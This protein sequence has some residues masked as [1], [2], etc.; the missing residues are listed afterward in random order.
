[1]K[2]NFAV[3]IL[4]HKR[5]SNVITYKTLKSHW[6]TWPIYII[7]DN[8]DPQI[9]EY[10]KN[11]D[12]V[13][14]F[15]KEKQYDQC[16]TIDNM[17][18]MWS[19]LYARNY[20]FELAKELWIDYFIEL[21]DDYTS[22]RF[23]YNKKW[24]W[25]KHKPNKSLDKTFEYMIDFLNS[26]DD[27]LTVAMAQGGDFIWW[28]DNWYLKS[29]PNKRKAMNS[30]LCK[31]SRKFQFHGT[32]NEDVN[33]YVWLWSIW[34]LFFSIPHISLNQKLTQTNA[35]GI[36]DLYK[37]NWTYV[38]SFYTI[39][40][41]PSSVKIAMMWNKN[42]RMH[43]KIDRNSTIPKIINEKYKKTV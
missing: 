10:K 38:K 11:F 31:T 39:I 20:S 15:D 22:F 17:H 7:V 21:D 23:S 2:Y 28:E 6:Y 19:I 5:S 3:F 24:E 35:W 16:D 36:T 13:Y 27:I 42:K 34:K 4:S 12:N 26:R 37:D 30:F 9:E 40:I 29:L 32:M 14:V 41:N 1:M 33:T 43:H 8:T 18:K 25:I